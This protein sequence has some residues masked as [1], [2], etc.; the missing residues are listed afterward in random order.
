MNYHAFFLIFIML[1]NSTSLAS[2]QCGQLESIY[3]KFSKF[4][5]TKIKDFIKTYGEF[6]LYQLK[7]EHLKE[8]CINQ[9][10]QEMQRKLFAS[11]QMIPFVIDRSCNIYFPGKSVKGKIPNHAVLAAQ[12]EIIGGGKIQCR[13][14]SRGESHFYI[15]NMS[16]RYCFSFAHLDRLLFR[17]MKL[18]ISAKDVFL[19][20]KQAK[21][22]AQNFDRA[23]KYQEILKGKRF[24]HGYKKSHIYRGDRFLVLTN[25]TK[26]NDQNP[27]NNTR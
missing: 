6:T 17:L 20:F 7:K 26:K 27:G 11:D 18:G 10:E 3:P 1:L 2:N 9:T 25:S 13:K 16:S 4:L 8:I 22:C 5:A 21:F 15:T 19:K 12:M 14:N 23:I 24:L